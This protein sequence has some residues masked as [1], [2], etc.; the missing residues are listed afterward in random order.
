MSCIWGKPQIGA[1]VRSSSSRQG[2][3]TLLRV[4][5]LHPL[6]HINIV[7]GTEFRVRRPRICAS[8]VADISREFARYSQ[9]CEV[10]VRHKRRCGFVVVSNPHHHSTFDIISAQRIVSF[11]SGPSVTFYPAELHCRLQIRSDLLPSLPRANAQMWRVRTFCA[12]EQI[13][14]HIPR[15]VLSRL[16][17]PQWALSTQLLPR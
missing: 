14:F 9:W 5:G 13:V 11:L 8:A 6:L 2:T 7:F 1:C 17:Q 12:S 10:S 15:G 4:L 3:C 16:S